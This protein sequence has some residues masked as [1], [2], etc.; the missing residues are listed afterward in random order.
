GYLVVT[1]IV[2][3]TQHYQLSVGR[4]QKTND[5]FNLSAPLFARIL[6]LRRHTPALY[7]QI[8]GFAVRLCDERRIA[9]RMASKMINGSV[10]RDLINPRGEFEL[11]AIAIERVVDFDENFLRKI[12]GGFVIAD[13]AINI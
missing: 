10:M 8:V 5:P 7:R 2:R 6:L 11:R 12:E 13:H 4:R 1:Q 3:M 9:H